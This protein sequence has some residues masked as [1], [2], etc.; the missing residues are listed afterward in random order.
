[1]SKRVILLLPIALFAVLV[2]AFLWGLAPDRDP[3][4]VPS[5]MVDKPAP[6]FDLPSVTGLDIPGLKTGDLTG[7]VILVNFFAS[8]CVPCRVEHPVFMDLAARGDV[9]LV[10]IN[11]RDEPA[12]AVA[13]LAELG[14]P[15]S[16]IGADL[17]ARTGIDWGV[18]GVP[19]TYVIDS[20]GRIRYQ[21]I[22]P[23][24]PRHY[25]ETIRPMIEDLR[26]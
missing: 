16:R 3:S 9:K 10:A 22:G 26:Q 14:N 2:G 23:M 17:D 19:E 18:S 25:E 1:M 6:D 15:Y 20:S 24:L 11:Y 4:Q 7:E 13:W 12:D 5:A 21:H 8:W